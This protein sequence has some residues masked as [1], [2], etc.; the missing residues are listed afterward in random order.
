MSTSTGNTFGAIARHSLIYGI[1]GIISRAVSFVMLPLYTHYLTPRDY[2]T[3]ELLSSTIDIISIVA[4]IGL[5]SAIFK[6]YSQYEDKKDKDEVMSTAMILLLLISLTTAITGS[7]FS[8]HISKIVFGSEENSY[9]FRIIF[10]IYF[11]DQG[12]VMVPLMMIRAENRSGLFV[13]I[14]TVKLF[15][16]IFFNI[17]FI[18]VL[19]INILGILYSTLLANLAIGSF[20]SYRAFRRTGFLFSKR[21]GKEMIRFGYPFIFVSLSS[22][23]LTY[24]DRYFLNI[25][26]NLATI[27]I[28]A[29]AYKFGFLMGYLSADPFMQIWEPQRFEIAKQEDALLIFKKAFQYFNVLVVLVSL[30]ICIFVKDALIVMS[31]AVYVEAYK[32]VPI[33]VLAYIIQ[34]WTFYCNLGI[35]IKN[36]SN[37]MA[38]ASFF[39]TICVIGL[40]F[41]LIPKYGA[42]GAAWA[43]VGAFLI[44][45]VLVYYFSQKMYPINYGLK[46]QAALL[47]AAA[48]IYAAGRA[49]EMQQLALSLMV[50][51]VLVCLFIAGTYFIFLDD[52]E[53]DSMRSIVQMPFAF[54][55]TVL[56]ERS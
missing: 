24:S 46:K 42:Y 54:I 17:Y 38:V 1:G 9:Y 22:F 8:P 11:L 36:R 28:Y 39:A 44:R 12:A 6:Y 33:V 56:N 29:L 32:M 35:Y 43:T 19:K 37:T 15:I 14:S 41:L 20:L 10:L 23:A 5:A 51:T 4:G 52:K 26:S 31:K 13:G 2:G 47:A 21:K 7:I 49:I 45:F 34:A 48:F 27:G 53:K 40:N 16:Q 55:R 25:Y 3:M 30:V 18:V 50:N